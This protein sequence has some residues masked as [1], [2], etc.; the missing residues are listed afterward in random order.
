MQLDDSF[1]D[2]KTQTGTFLACGWPNAGFAK[3]GK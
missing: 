3:I 1:D 2:G